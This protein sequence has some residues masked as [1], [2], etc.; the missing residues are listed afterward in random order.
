M[1]SLLIALGLAC[2]VAPLAS[3]APYGYSNTRR[4]SSLIA[5]GDSWSDNGNVAR[6]TNGSW[7][8]S[9]IYYKGRFSNGPIWLDRLIDEHR[10]ASILYDNAYGSATSNDATLKGLTGADST[11]PVPSVNEQIATW[12]ES[13]ASANAGRN[14]LYSVWSGG[15]DYF[16]DAFAYHLNLTS[17]KVEA[18]TFANVERLLSPPFN[19]KNILVVNLPDLSLLPF[20]NTLGSASASLKAQ[21]KALAT[22]HNADLSQ[23]VET[24]LKTLQNIKIQILDV[25]ALV[26]KVWGKPEK[27]GFKDLVNPCYDGK[28]VCA[29]PDEHFWWDQFHFSTRAH[30]LIADTAARTIRH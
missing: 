22:A 29:N 8:L 1:S 12:G 24:K 7:P 23:S 30:A 4:H 25:H 27:F 3:A 19:A 28:T 18:D 21:F 2:A 14:P 20:F 15:N 5:F 26:E 17:E 10:I 9:N 11:I 6:L 16:F 13:L